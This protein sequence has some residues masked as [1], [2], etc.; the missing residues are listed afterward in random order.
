MVVR[1]DPERKTPLGSMRTITDFLAN[2]MT[3]V[4]RPRGETIDLLERVMSPSASTPPGEMRTLLAQV[5]LIRTEFEGLAIERLY[6]FEMRIPRERVV[7][8]KDLADRSSVTLEDLMERGVTW[9]EAPCS[10]DDI[11]HFRQGLSEERERPGPFTI[12]DAFGEVLD[13]LEKS[14]AHALEANVDLACE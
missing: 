6:K 1:S 10:P 14:A 9:G 3:H 4:M 8:L 2:V 5:R 7:E 11:E 13:A 12:A